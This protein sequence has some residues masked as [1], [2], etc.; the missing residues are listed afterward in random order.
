MPLA[1]VPLLKSCKFSFQNYILLVPP[2]LDAT[3]LLTDRPINFATAYRSDC[4][5]GYDLAPELSKRCF[6]WLFQLVMA[7][8]DKPSPCNCTLSGSRKA[9]CSLIGGQCPC[10]RHVIG[11]TCSTCAI[12]RLAYPRCIAQNSVKRHLPFGI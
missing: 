6:N 9:S 1:L 10:K 5:K 4:I 8:N 12:G 7:F 2:T 11:R 3:R